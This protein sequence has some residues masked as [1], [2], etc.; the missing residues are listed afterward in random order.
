M[1]TE[2]KL[3]LLGDLWEQWKGCTRCKLCQPTGRVRKNVVFGSG[4]PN[5][6]LM[7]VGEGP[8]GQEDEHGEPFWPTA[9]SGDLLDR[10]LASFNISRDEVFI[11]NVVGCW[12]TREDDPT[13]SRPPDDDEVAACRPRLERII[14]I[15]DPYVLLLLGDT[16]KAALTRERKSVT[17][18][19]RDSDFPVVKAIT[20]G[21]CFE[22]ER[23]A[24]VTF[25]PAYLA[26]KLDMTTGS[27]THLVYQAFEKAFTLVRA[28]EHL[29][30]NAPMPAREGE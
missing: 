29:Y 19:A 13:K 8:G 18:L 11:V 12:P 22:V 27:D 24:I 4:N 14:E 21:Q 25:H 10:F 9:P 17:A 26:R 7:I 1:D 2:T 23:P 30:F 3:R 6:K 5:A 16:A 15:V 20:R 28:Y